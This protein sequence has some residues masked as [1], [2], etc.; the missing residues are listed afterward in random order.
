MYDE[1]LN[2]QEI[3]SETRVALGIYAFDFF[4]LLFYAIFTYMLRN[5]VHNAIRIPYYIFSVCMAIFLTM[6]STF[7]R[8][9]RNYQSLIIMLKRDFAVYRPVK[10]IG[11]QREKVEE[12]NNKNKLNE[13]RMMK[14]NG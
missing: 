3:K 11:Q 12:K 5:M 2:P 8:K 1:Y 13:Q 6:P 4:F 9:R 14:I 7:N 10:N